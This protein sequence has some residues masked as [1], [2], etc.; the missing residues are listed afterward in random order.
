[1]KAAAARVKINK[2]PED[3]GWRFFSGPDGPASI[4]LEPS[5]TLKKQDLDSLG[6]DFEKAQ[7]GFID[8]LLLNEKGFP[9]LVRPAYLSEK[10]IGI[11]AA[12]D[13]A[14]EF[15]IHTNFPGIES[16]HQTLR[17]TYPDFVPESAPTT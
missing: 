15:A 13:I 7:K 9:L 6:T 14:D 10:D 8:F 2:L 12:F 11:C 1:M 4:Q 16:F 5:V 17:A 3:A